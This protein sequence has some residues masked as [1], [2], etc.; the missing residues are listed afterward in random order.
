MAAIVEAGQVS[1]N[2]KPYPLLPLAPP[3]GKLVESSLGSIYPQKQ[4][5][6]DYTQDSQPYASVHTWR[7]WT[8]GIGRDRWGGPEDD[9]RSWYSECWLRNK[10]H[11]LLPP[12]VTATA[13]ATGAAIPG[14]M[15]NLNGNL[16]AVTGTALTLV[17]LYTPGTD[18]WGASL[19]T[20]A[21]SP[22]AIGVNGYIGATEYM[23]WAL[24]G[25]NG[26]TVATGAGPTFTDSAKAA[27]WLAF[28][29]DKLWGL[30]AVGQLWYTLT[31]GS[32]EVN[33]ALLPARTSGLPL[34]LFVGPDASGEPILYAISNNR[35]FAH[36][37]ANQRFLRLDVAAAGVGNSSPRVAT[38][39]GNIYVGSGSS[40]IEY[41]PTKGTIR[42]IG[43]DVLDGVPATNNYIVNSILATQY[44]L[45]VGTS[46]LDG[47]VDMAPLLSWDGQGWQV[48]FVETSIVTQDLL[49]LNGTG[50]STRL[51]FRGAANG[52]MRSIQF[53]PDVQNPKQISGY[54]YAASAVH[55]TPWFNAKQEEV[56]KTLTE[57][58]VDVQ[59]TTANE[60][61][62]VDIAYD[63]AEGAADA[64]YTNLGTITA[65]GTTS[66]L[67]P[68]STTPSGTDFRA[69]RIKL[70][71]KNLVGGGA[72][73]S[74]PDVTSVT[75]VYRKK[76][77]V[78]W[79]HRCRIDLRKEFGGKTPKELR[80]DLQ[81]AV[82][83]TTKV[84]F[85][86][87]D[88]SGTARDFYGDIVQATGL[89]NTG[90]DETGES[91]ITF[92]E[93]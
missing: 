19:K 42:N 85:T 11:L 4:I 35:L 91:E 18:T 88:A 69:V 68:N 48:L 12:L 45:I 46:S 37:F 83:V 79:T 34:G 23:G 50:V 84:E 71:L 86:F 3:G 53:A 54:T 26:Y 70:T 60:T 9:K 20:L 28:W 47:S 5:T 27:N 75:L 36:D 13:D 7:E 52:K 51:Y 72:N 66:Y 64:S 90:L 22:Y 31:P 49:V 39:N 81:T 73:T 17:K 57:I 32:G 25:T 82:R 77:P 92:V 56:A 65:N 33:D 2:G 87:R 14:G 58:R 62:K 63:Y 40:I 8:D 1:I 74:S 76:L 80:A 78:K 59:D 89:E 55:K 61:V 16:Y 6:G 30:S 15:V 44:A 41:S 29:D 24:A 43:P 10:N 38:W 93:I 21:A 67:I